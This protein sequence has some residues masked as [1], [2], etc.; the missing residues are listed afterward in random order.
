MCD[1]E[2]DTVHIDQESALDKTTDVVR[3]SL[4]LHDFHH[5]EFHSLGSCQYHILLVLVTLKLNLRSDDANVIAALRDKFFS[6]SSHQVFD[7]TV[8]KTLGVGTP[9]GRGELA[10][11]A[12]NALDTLFQI[13]G[14]F[15]I[16]PH[17]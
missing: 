14:C 15:I 2:L 10:T 11:I 5:L 12:K 1:E 6:N 4:L 17:T 8:D 3:Y 16:V 13:H 7:R 9:S